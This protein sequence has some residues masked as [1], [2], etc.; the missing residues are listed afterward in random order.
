MTLSWGAHRC[1]LPQLSFTSRPI[2]L[3]VY[4]YGRHSRVTNRARIFYDI[5]TESIGSRHAAHGALSWKC[6]EIFPLGGSRRIHGMR[7]SIRTEIWRCA[8]ALVITARGVLDCY[9]AAYSSESTSMTIIF[10]FMMQLMKSRASAKLGFM[11]S[12]RRWL[13]F[14]RLFHYDIYFWRIYLSSIAVKCRHQSES[15]VAALS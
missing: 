10:L 2:R 6:R 7:V 9:N 3:C 11:G 8:G 1:G 13:Y 15:T 5:T 14:I 4:V 12:C